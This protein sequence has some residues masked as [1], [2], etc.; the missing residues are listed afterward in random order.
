MGDV[1]I[2]LPGDIGREGEAEILRHLRPARSVVLKAPHHG[3]ATSSGAELL[4][5]LRPSLVV[6]SAGRANRFGHPAPS[7]RARYRAL[8]STMFSSA[9]DGA[10]ILDTD[11]RTVRVRGWTG[12][13]VRFSAG[14]SRP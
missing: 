7:V 12:R 9:E 5:A 2:V 6:F 4:E 3:S 14:S 13:Q 11:G 8:G 10:V 1:S